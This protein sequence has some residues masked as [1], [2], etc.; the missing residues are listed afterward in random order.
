[1]PWC[2]YALCTIR[3]HGYAASPSAWASPSGPSRPLPDRGW[4]STQFRAERAALLATCKGGG[5]ASRRDYAISH[6][7][8]CWSGVRGEGASSVTEILT[9]PVSAL[10]VWRGDEL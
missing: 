10:N 1:M 8:S 7:M 4:A 2:C 5:F 3:Q 9:E 6:T